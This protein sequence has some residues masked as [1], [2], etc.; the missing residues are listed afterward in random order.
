[1][2]CT[3]KACVIYTKYVYLKIAK[4]AVHDSGVYT[5]NI[6]FTLVVND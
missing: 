1:M 6:Y 5:T 2:I 3:K 4:D